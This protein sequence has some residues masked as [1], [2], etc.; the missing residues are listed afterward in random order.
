MKGVGGI[1]YDLLIGIID[2]GFCF[3]LNGRDREI[4]CL[5]MTDE[6][7][8]K[9]KYREDGSQK[10]NQSFNHRHMQSAI[11]GSLAVSAI[12]IFNKIAGLLRLKD[13]HRSKKD[14]PLVKRE[15]TKQRN[16]SQKPRPHVNGN[17]TCFSFI[18]IIIGNAGE[19]DAGS[20][21]V[22]RSVP[23]CLARRRRQSLNSR[24]RPRPRLKTAVLRLHKRNQNK[25]VVE[26]KLKDL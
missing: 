13:E 6:K 1:H 4:S 7:W 10:R 20:A 22:S 21:V 3:F 9:T 25:S 14:F 24:P 17:F 19:E 16:R 8:R 26:T 23:A 15:K 5:R 11:A 2:I 12:T 18:A